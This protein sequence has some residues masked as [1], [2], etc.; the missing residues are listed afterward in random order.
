MKHTLL[1]LAFAGVLA[2][3][4]GVTAPANAAGAAALSASTSTAIDQRAPVAAQVQTVDHRGWRH[5]D[6]DRW[7][8]RSHG[9][10]YRHYDR[11]PSFS[12]HFGSPGY[13]YAPRYRVAPAPRY[14]H[15]AS[16]AHVRWCES[17]YRS[18]NAWDNTWQ[19]YHGPRRQCFSPYS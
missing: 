11:G 16:S 12:L 5:R 14:R 9:P 1:A 19:P 2:I 17:R 15:R 3:G 6:R 13:Y 8:H 10:R 4:A 18:Y 7:R